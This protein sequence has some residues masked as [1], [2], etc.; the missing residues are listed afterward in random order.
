[1]VLPDTNDVYERIHLLR[2]AASILETQQDIADPRFIANAM[3][4]TRGVAQFAR[5]VEKHEHR[6]TIPVTNSHERGQALPT[7]ITLFCMPETDTRAEGSA[8]AATAEL[9]VPCKP[10]GPLTSSLS[11]LDAVCVCLRAADE[12]WQLYRLF[13]WGERGLRTQ[14]TRVFIPL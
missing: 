7:S 13:I 10:G 1:M 2:H 14:G 6:R 4:V 12:Q 8:T 9:E 3:R 5:D 11:R